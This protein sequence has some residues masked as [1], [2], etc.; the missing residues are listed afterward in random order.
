M[1]A[2]PVFNR[3]PMYYARFV[4][5]RKNYDVIARAAKLP[6]AIRIPYAPH[7]RERIATSLRSSQ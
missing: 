1:R 6:V 7:L 5:A 4:P 3:Y 2:T